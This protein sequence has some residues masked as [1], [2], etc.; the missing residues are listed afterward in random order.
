MCLI[1]VVNVIPE[2]RTLNGVLEIAH[3]L[4]S[5]RSD[6]HTNQH[7]GN[8]FICESSRRSDSIDLIS[9]RTPPPQVQVA[10]RNVDLIKVPKRPLQSRR[11]PRVIGQIVKNAWHTKELFPHWWLAA[12]IP[13]EDIPR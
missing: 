13:G 6:D 1:D 5:I 12:R 9:Y 10:G 4:I 2:L 8:R 11:Q 7:A 3:Y